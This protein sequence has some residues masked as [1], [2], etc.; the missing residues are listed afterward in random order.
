[1]RKRLNGLEYGGR[2]GSDDFAV[3]KANSDG[4]AAELWRFFEAQKGKWNERFFEYMIIRR[5]TM[6]TVVAL[7]FD[8]MSGQKLA[9]ELSGIAAK[10]SPHISLKGRFSLKAGVSL[11]ELR[12]LV[13]NVVGELECVR[14]N[15]GPPIE[16]RRG[17]IWR[18]ITGADEVACLKHIH[19]RLNEAL[20]RSGLMD[21]D[22]TP[23][24]YR[25]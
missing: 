8:R 7:G 21:A 16:V 17:L 25:K 18:E 12:D 24:M 15:L 6:N 20:A 13:L 11:V 4:L 3:L 1:M 14:Y 23:T 5:T 2:Y 9:K 19:M 22:K 10:F